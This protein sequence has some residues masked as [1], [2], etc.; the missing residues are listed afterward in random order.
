MSER[1]PAGLIF[2]IDDKS[3]E[4]GKYDVIVRE[5]TEDMLSPK[6]NW[7]NDNIGQY[8]V[9]DRDDRLFKLFDTQAEANVYAN[10]KNLTFE[11]APLT[12]YQPTREWLSDATLAERKRERLGREKDKEMDR[13]KD[14]W[15]E[16]TS[17]L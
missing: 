8:A 13:Q 15:D 2:G 17:E 1:G 3:G 10:A 11:K 6:Q 16:L 14:R 4:G 12:W 5:V 7:V 9:L